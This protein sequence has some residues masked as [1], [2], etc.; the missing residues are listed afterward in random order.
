MLDPDDKKVVLASFNAWLEI[1][2]TRKELNEENKAVIKR[3][4]ESLETDPKFVRKLFSIMKQ[5]QENGVDEI[6]TL[7]SL[8]LEI[9]N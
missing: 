7:S 9:E 3:A 5:K 4:A 2:D 8:L 1:H 6:D